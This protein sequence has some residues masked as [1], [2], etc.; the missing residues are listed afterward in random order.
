MG[1]DG[2]GGCDV[3]GTWELTLSAV[4]GIHH[5]ENVEYKSDGRTNNSIWRCLVLGF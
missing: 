1:G 2:G 4:S 5:D 3:S